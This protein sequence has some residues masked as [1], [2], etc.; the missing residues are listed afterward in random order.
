MTEKRPDRPPTAHDRQLTAARG[1]IDQINAN[2]APD[3]EV[4]IWLVTRYDYLR[5]THE[6]DHGQR[7]ELAEIN[8]KLYF[9]FGAVGM[10]RIDQA[11]SSE[12]AKQ[13]REQR[14]TP[15]I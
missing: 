14:M 9:H 11:Y 7:L 3:G 1:I 5:R 4:G 6:L 13:K 10:L 12:G 2:G 15:N 8:F